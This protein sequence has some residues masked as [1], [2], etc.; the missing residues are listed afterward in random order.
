MLQQHEPEVLR[1]R[2]WRALFSPGQFRNSLSCS[3]FY[4]LYP[5]CEIEIAFNVS[6]FRLDHRGQ[7]RYIYTLLVIQRLAVPF[8]I[9]LEIFEVWKL[10]LC[11]EKGGFYEFAYNEAFFPLSRILEFV[12][13]PMTRCLLLWSYFSHLVCGLLLEPPS[14]SGLLGFLRKGRGQQELIVKKTRQK[15]QVK[16][17]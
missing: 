3:F 16:K 15:S 1:P 5:L 14:A 2:H 12:L 10:F 13:S 11:S 8:S 7:R 17:A 6:C 4:Y 9:N